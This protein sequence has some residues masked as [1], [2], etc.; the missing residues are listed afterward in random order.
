MNLLRTV[1][2]PTVLLA[3]TASVSAWA[4]KPVAKHSADRPNILLIL[5]DD[6]GY[7]DLGAFGSEIETPNIDR[8]ATEGHTLTNLHTTP[9]CSTSRA[10]LLTGADHH[11]VGVGNLAD[12]RPL[13]GDKASY[14]GELNGN[15]RTV[16]QLLRDAGYHSY[17]AGKWHLGKE[18]P[19]KWGF[20]QS[21]SLNPEAAYANN[22]AIQGKVTG[23]RGESYF[24]NGKRAVLPDDFF[25]SNYFVDRLQQYITQDHDDGKPF[26]AYLPFQAMHFPIQA[27]DADLQRY[28]GRYDAGYEVIGAERLA[29]QKKLGLIPADFQ[30]NPGAEAKMWRFG[31]PGL[32]RNKPWSELSEKDR[33]SEARV[34]EVYAAMLSNLDANVGRLIDTLKKLGVYDNTL[35]VFTADNGAD[36]IG[37]GFVPYIDKKL[38]F[39]I[40]NSLE[41]YGKASSFLFRSSRWAEVGSTPFRL[42]KAF[43]AEGGITAATIIKQPSKASGPKV[44]QALATDRDIVPTI[45]ALA[46]IADPGAQYQGRAVA[47]IEGVSLLPALTGNKREV[48]SDTE[49]F[50]D[51]VN[52]IRYVR[53]GPWKLTRINNKLMPSAARHLPHQWQLYDI[54]KDRGETRDVAAQHPE[55]VAELKAE[56]R[57]YVKRVGVLQ[58]SLPFFMP[59]LDE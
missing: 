54:V 26:F 50:A 42:F 59:S 11:L 41:N 36:G 25:S 17:M 15:A 30:A 7:S 19:E 53:R 4:A 33:R 34:M 22:F 57:A 47:P 48:H 28:R 23:S 52:E 43:T 2:L 14:G 51:E 3:A 1:V 16:A 5:V 37:Y 24:E 18:G 39:D 58:P 44:V 6:L 10:N 45:L 12:L 8:L 49:V 21:F 13:Y 40:D 31:S 20:E 27:P 38:N 56:W 9:L 29:R 35:I 46:G 32:R 55:V